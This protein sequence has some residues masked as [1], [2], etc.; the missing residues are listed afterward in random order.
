MQIPQGDG[1][2]GGGHSAGSS[3]YYTP[4][5]GLPLPSTQGPL[6]SSLQQQQMQQQQQYPSPRQQQRRAASIELPAGAVGGVRPQQQLGS[7]GL[8]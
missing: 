5:Q 4:Q 8:S 6:T 7:G 2:G 1:G 3:P